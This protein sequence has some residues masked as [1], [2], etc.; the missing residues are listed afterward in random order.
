MVTNHN[1]DGSNDVY[2]LGVKQY[3]YNENIILSG[4]SR[5]SHRT[6]VYDNVSVVRDYQIITRNRYSYNVYV[7]TPIASFDYGFFSIGWA[8]PVDYTWGWEGAPWYGS[9]NYYFQPRRHYLRASDI[10]VDSLVSGYLSSRYDYQL[11]AARE[12][13]QQANIEIENADR[14]IRNYEQTH[15]QDSM[16]TQISVQAQEVLNDHRKGQTENIED[17]LR[18]P[19]YVYLVSDPRQ[20]SIVG[21]DN[22]CEVTPGDA[23]Q[24][25]G[26]VDLDEGSASME[27]VS[28]Q[29]GDCPLHVH[30]NV[31]LSDLQEFHNRFVQN[32]MEKDALRIL[33]ERSSFRR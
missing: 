23:L 19:S 6:Y 33:K 29:V 22:L 27:V 9:Y 31:S 16:M 13:E 3:S 32:I 10:L 18:N 14:I 21:S 28:S 25:F 30:V 12:R 17:L 4:S 1:P 20:L 24:L 2:A 8:T 26:D 15:M 11:A 7:P 5:T